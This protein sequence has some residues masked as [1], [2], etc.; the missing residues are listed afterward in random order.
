MYKAYLIDLDGTAYHGT[1]VVQETLEF[2]QKL[3]QRNIPYLF[4]TNNSTKTPAMVAK[5]LSEFGY[6]VSPEQVYTS[7]MATAEYIYDE[8]P[9]AKIFMIGEIGL[10]QAL[11]DKGLLLVEEGMAADYVAFGLDRDVTYEK[12][13]Q[14][15]FAIRNGAKYVVTNGDKAIPTER[16]LMPGNGSLASVITVSTGEEPI[17][18]GKPHSTIMKKALELLG[19]P[20]TEVAVIGDN[21]HTDI[22]GGIKEGVPSIFIE[23]GVSTREEVLAYEHQPTHVLKDLSEWGL[24][25][26]M[27][28]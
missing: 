25:E 2:V 10:E 12:L 23:G 16:G 24:E 14:A 1:A 3:H 21:Y 7:A 28:A 18:I 20:A 17:V 5:H 26:A 15:C 19:L 11:S 9:H 13:G 8:N 27:E 4:L 22:L 6:P